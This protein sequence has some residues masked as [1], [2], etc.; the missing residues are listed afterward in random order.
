LKE[1]DSHQCFK[2]LKNRNSKVNDIDYF[3]CP[4]HRGSLR[5]LSNPQM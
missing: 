2:A 3:I 1:V 4:I 5:L